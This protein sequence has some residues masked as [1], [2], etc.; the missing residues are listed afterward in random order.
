MYTKGDSEIRIVESFSEKG[1]P[2]IPGFESEREHILVNNKKGAI[3]P[4][5]GGNMKALAWQNG[6][7]LEVTDYL[8]P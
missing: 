2:E 7:E 5:F 4:V 1:L 3:S 8:L 6:G